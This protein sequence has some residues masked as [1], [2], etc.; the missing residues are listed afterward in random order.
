MT[1]CDQSLRQAWSHVKQVRPPA[2]PSIGFMAELVKLDAAKCGESASFSL[3]EYRLDCC[4]E[5]FPS[6]SDDV[7]LDALQR[8]HD[9]VADEAAVHAL[10]QKAGTENLEPLGYLAIDLLMAEH[11]DKFVKR[12]GCSAHH[13]FD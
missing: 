1:R 13:P 5:I 8:A 3:E 7:C 4:K 2:C 11:E 6:L 12:R 10:V 9:L